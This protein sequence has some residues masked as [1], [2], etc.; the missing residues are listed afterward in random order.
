MANKHDGRVSH[1]SASKIHVTHELRRLIFEEEAQDQTAQLWRK[2][3]QSSWR[4]LLHWMLYLIVKFGIDLC[5]ALSCTSHE[6]HDRETEILLRVGLCID[7]S[8]DAW[9]QTMQNP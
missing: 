3:E 8:F 5:Y 2:T 7:I 6:P 9:H 4:T 1:L